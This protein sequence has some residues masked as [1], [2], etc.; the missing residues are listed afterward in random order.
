MMSCH[1]GEFGLPER[2]TT[3]IQRVRAI[4]LSTGSWR[5]AIVSP[6]TWVVD[7]SVST[8]VSA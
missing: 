7:S 3:A 1:L 4:A 2:D 6:S 8:W 5:D